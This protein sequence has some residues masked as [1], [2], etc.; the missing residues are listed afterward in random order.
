MPRCITF[1]IN[2]AHSEAT[3][4]KI[5]NQETGVIKLYITRD[6]TIKSNYNMF[7]VVFSKEPKAYTWHFIEQAEGRFK[8]KYVQ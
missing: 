6:D 7:T 3:V 1:S 2:G 8:S 5:H 4:T